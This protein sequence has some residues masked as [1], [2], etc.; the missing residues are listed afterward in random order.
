MKFCEKCGAQMKDEA[1]LCVACGCMVR[2]SMVRKPVK[3]VQE[4]SKRTDGERLPAVIFCSLGHAVFS[5][6]SIFFMGLSIIFS[7]IAYASR[8]G[9]KSY[10]WSPKES[11]VFG[12][13]I[14]GI[15]ALLCGLASFIV[16]LAVG[17]KNR[18][19]FFACI[20]KLTSSVLLII[21]PVVVLF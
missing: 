14:F 10:V 16:G 19:W 9:N 5:M 6:L 1:V 17:T 15:L 3:A 21:M 12:A 7:E 13:L 8:F 18:E 20:A 11:F 4:K 2:E